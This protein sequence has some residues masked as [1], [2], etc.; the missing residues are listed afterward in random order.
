[1]HQ[2]L[3]VYLSSVR[4]FYRKNSN[5]EVNTL[6]WVSANSSSQFSRNESNM[7]QDAKSS[8]FSWTNVSFV[9]GPQNYTV[10]AIKGQ[11]MMKNGVRWRD[12]K[13]PTLQT[14]LTRCRWIH[15]L[16]IRMK[17]NGIQSLEEYENTQ[18]KKP[19]DFPLLSGNCLNWFFPSWSLWDSIRKKQFLTRK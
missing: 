8:N 11:Q 12:V 7:N 3:F 18:N 1:M 6:K 15:V 17:T 5:L 9:F 16:K 19:R 10:L 14:K 2:K 4:F 13:W